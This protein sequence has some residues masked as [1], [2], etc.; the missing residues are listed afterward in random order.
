[1][2]ERVLITGASGFIGYHII[3]EAL[4]NNLEVY[5]AI[6]KSSNIDHLKGLDIKYTFLDFDNVSSLKREL[7]E[8]KYAY[9]IHAAGVTKARS[10]EE[11][12]AIN[13]GYTHNLASASIES[14]ILL[15]KFVLLGSLAASGPLNNLDEVLTESSTPNPVTA[16]GKSKLLGEEQ[17]K[18]FSTLNYTILKPTGVYG[19]RDKD[20]FIFFKQ[21]A[22]GIEPYIGNIE[23]K[24]SFLYVTD[25]ARAT[26]KALFCCHQST[27]ILSDG[28]SYDR[29]QLAGF[30]KESMGVKAVKLHLPV[31]FVKIIAYLAEKYCALNKKA[32][33]LNVEK[34]NELMAVNWDCDI[35][36]ARTVLGFKPEYDLKAGVAESIKW[37][38]TNKWL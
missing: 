1:M 21:V 16:Y 9:I 19:P 25:L 26:I 15:K 32:S 2:K 36:N 38:K 13:A 27:F 17:L 8:K 3:L 14:G 33:T 18:A 31:K 37:Y 7:A 4:K 11:Y 6:R 10:Q 5:A 20:I 34:L 30:I 35:E 22:K 23:Q 28:N 29:Y 12:N 24:F